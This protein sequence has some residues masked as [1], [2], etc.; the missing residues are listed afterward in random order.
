MFQHLFL[1][2]WTID[3]CRATV[4]VIGIDCV[5]FF[6]YCFPLTHVELILLCDWRSDLHKSQCTGG[7]GSFLLYKAATNDYFPVDLTC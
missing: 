2:A 3:L 5:A 4:I 6:C 7:S 1:D